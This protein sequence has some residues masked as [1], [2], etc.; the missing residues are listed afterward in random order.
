METMSLKEIFEQDEFLHYTWVTPARDFI[1]KYKL[2][3]LDEFLVNPVVATTT[4]A[5]SDEINTAY[6][7]GMALPLVAKTWRAD[8][9][10]TIDRMTKDIKNNIEMGSVEKIEKQAD[11]TFLVHTSVGEYAATNIVLAAPHKHIAHLYPGVPEPY[12]QVDIHVMKVVG[13]RKE[14]FKNKP[15]VFP[16]S[17]EHDGVYTLFQTKPGIDL[18]YSK[19]ANPDL[20]QYYSEYNIEHCV[21]WDPVMNVPDD[22]LID[23]KIDDHVYLAGDYNISGLEEAYVSGMSVGRRVCRDNKRN[24]S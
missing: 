6:Y 15:V 17:R 23:N 19:K 3:K 10:H 2:E 13:K 9:T 12:K 24:I 4:Y 8:F 16:R 14:P 22:R 11:G 21:Y 5:E 18:V 1:K 7:L 20:S